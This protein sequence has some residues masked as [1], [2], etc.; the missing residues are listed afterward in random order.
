MMNT[1]RIACIGAVA[2]LVAA[3][4]AR[5]QAQDANHWSWHGAIPAGKTLEIRGING[6]IR[7]DASTGSEVQVTAEK[8]GRDDDPADVRIEVVP[9]EGGVTICAVYP[10]TG[11]EC[12]PGGGRMRVHDNDVEVRFVA[13]V[14]AGVA[15]DGNNV[16]GGVEAA[17]LTGPVDLTTVNGAVAL[18]TTAGEASAS[19]VNGGIHATVRGAGQGRLSFSTVN[20]S[21]DLSLAGG[22][23]ADF[24][25]ETVNGSIESD[26]P[27]TLTGR[28]N[29]RHLEGRIGQGG[30]ILRLRTVNGGIRV[31]SLP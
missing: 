11:N 10:G 1:I 23:S 15:F 28:I 30:R 21:V 3:P 4:A 8:H 5:A 7:A 9:H 18:E 19:T 20:G 14:P 22:L 12:R 13:R 17:G 6:S 2:L 25:A 26:F 16:N 27:I 24:S 31:H 29:P